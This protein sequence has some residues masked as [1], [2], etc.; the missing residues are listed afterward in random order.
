MSDDK[1][2]VKWLFSNLDSVNIA[3]SLPEDVLTR[4][5]MDVVYG[6]DIDKQSRIVW[7]EKAEAGLGIAMQV[8]QT[9]TT[10]WPN[11][12]NV[13]HPLIAVAA[14]QFAARAYPNIV[15]GTDVVKAQVI[16][17][18][19]EGKKEARA[20]RV[21]Q[22][23]SWQLTE[24][25]EEWEEDTDKLLHCLPIFGIYYR[26]TYFDPLLGRNCSEGRSPLS[27][28]VNNGVKSLERAR[29]I[30]DEVYLYKNEVIER[31]RAD[32]FSGET[33][34]KF[35]GDPQEKPQELYLEQHC[36]ADLD[37]DGYE[38]PYIVT[39]HKDTNTV[40]RVYPRYEAAGI[41]T[42]GK[43]IGRIDPIHYFTKY[44]FLPS[45]DGKF[46][47][48]GF[49]HL[50]GPLNETINTLINQLL[51][52]GTLANRQGGFIGRGIRWKGG[53]MTFTPGEWKPVD[54]AGGVLKENL[55][56]MPIKEPSGVL[57]QL[58]G[59]LSETADRLASVSEALTGE[60]PS[61]NT[62]ATTV[63]AMIEQGLKVFTSIYK[64]VFRSL[65]V[66]YKKMYRLNGLHVAEEE[67]YRVLDSQFAV[68][69]SDYALS[70]LDIVPVADPTISSEAQKLARARAEYE[71]MDRNPTLGGRLQILRNYYE[72]LEAKSIEKLLPPKEIDA[73][74]NPPPPPPNPDL[75]RLEADILKDKNEYELSMQKMDLERLKVEASVELAKAQ[76]IKAIAE[77]EAKEAGQQFEIYRHEVEQLATQTKMAIEIM[78]EKNRAREAAAEQGNSAGN[79]AGAAGGMEN[80]GLDEGGVQV[81]PPD[82]GGLEGDAGGGVV[83]VPGVGG[84]DGAGDGA[85]SGGSFGVGPLARTPI[86]G[87]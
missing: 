72:A 1:H 83:P 25:M 84:G 16:G 59:A 14:I 24:Q 70:D 75:L 38:E 67:Y 73:I 7:E 41:K 15:K 54:V 71:T 10:P 87:A 19:P 79:D 8:M 13:K 18:D 28:V 4:L 62:P 47:D 40:V 34:E 9:K 6:Y 27:V 43:E 63:L 22:H 29:R 17:A 37:G 56:P 5:G 69:K 55:V 46:H 45:P 36:F 60:M 26:K 76:A 80:T 35:T 61:Q 64:R 11:A 77:A 3:P 32:I 86:P 52:A 30:T 49:S 65:K 12:A 21:S 2:P 57:F 68:F 53:A 33:S 51:D 85:A 81:P 39:V 48:L 58:L 78:K 23:M 44:S 74:L 66:E 42:D 31:E 20:K 50:L 82:S